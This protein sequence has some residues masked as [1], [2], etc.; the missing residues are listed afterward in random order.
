MSRLLHLA[1]LQGVF[2]LVEEILYGVRT[3]K[4]IMDHGLHVHRREGQL[5][6]PGEDQLQL[7]GDLGQGIQGPGRVLF[8]QCRQRFFGLGQRRDRFG[9]GLFAFFEGLALD[10]LVHGRLHRLGH[11]GFGLGNGDFARVLAGSIRGVLGFLFIAHVCLLLNIAW[12]MGAGAVYR[13][14]PPLPVL[15]ELQIRSD[16]CC[17][18]LSNQPLPDLPPS[19]FFSICSICSYMGL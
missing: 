18:I 14:R 16:N 3:G 11:R 9:H 10:H 4:H 19:D 7:A 1:M 15:P 12:G 2:G 17:L 8:V 6:L 13:R 5:R